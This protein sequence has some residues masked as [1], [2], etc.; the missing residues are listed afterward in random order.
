MSKI[1]RYLF[2][3]IFCLVI[4]FGGNARKYGDYRS[5]APYAFVVDGPRKINVRLYQST[6]SALLTQLSHGDTVFV[7]SFATDPDD[8]V[9][10]EVSGNKGWIFK[11]GADASTKLREISNPYYFHQ[12]EE[13][14]PQQI[15]ESHKWGKIVFII[16]AVIAAALSVFWVIRYLNN[17]YDEADWIIGEPTAGGLRKRFFFN[18][19]PY[20]LIIA[21]TLMLIL[22]LVA[23]LIAMLAIGAAVFILLWVVK[24]LTYILL[25][26]FIIGGILGVLAMWG[27]DDEESKGIGCVGLIVGIVCIIFKD[28]ITNFADSCSEAGL[29]FLKEFNVLAF[30]VE[31]VKQY[32]APA[33]FWVS[34]PLMLFLACAVVWMIFAGILIAFE[35]LVTWRYNIKHPCPHCHESSEPALYLS[36]GYAPMPDDVPLRPGAYGLFHITHPQTGE[37]MPTMLLNGRDTLTRLCPHCN[38]RINAKEGAERHMIL[39]GGPESGKSTLAYRFIAELIRMGYEPEFTDQK[40]TIDNSDSVIRKIKEIAETGKITEKSLPDKT[41]RGQTGA[42]QVMLRRKLSPVDYRLFINDLAGEVFN[43]LVQGKFEN[44]KLSFFRDANVLV[45]LIDPYTMRFDRCTND[46]VNDWIRT[47][48]SDISDDMKMNPMS[49]KTALDTGISAGAIKRSNLRVDIVLTKTDAG[50]IPSHVNLEDPDALRAFITGSLGLAPL[51]LWAE[52]MKEV[53]FFA[54]AAMSQG[55]SSRMEPFARTVLKQLDIN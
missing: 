17:H 48:A 28:S 53:R 6:S 36:M 13:F 47:H 10:Y 38:H 1:L 8:Q 9:W 54:V 27:G 50:Y 24:I 4:A 22:S 43:D 23:S 40:N 7:A 33:L 3:S 11:P 46:Y 2:L 20:Q 35:A 51:V 18:W 52:G 30:G 45:I 34:V 14:T 55:D 32:W 37:E 49:L 39:A 12:Q 42:M 19:E 41:G 21:I 26:L 31:L 15:E 25:W 5:T 29:A 44:G 16:L